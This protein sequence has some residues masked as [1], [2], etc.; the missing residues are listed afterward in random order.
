[1]PTRRSTARNSTPLAPCYRLAKRPWS[2]RAFSSPLKPRN[3]ACDSA[4]PGPHGP[5]VGAIPRKLDTGGLS[6]HSTP[7]L[8][9]KILRA[10]QRAPAR[11]GPGG[12]RPPKGVPGA[13]SR[14]ASGAAFPL[15]PSGQKLVLRRKRKKEKK[16]KKKSC[17]SKTSWRSIWPTAE[18]GVPSW[19]TKCNNQ[20]KRSWRWW[21]GS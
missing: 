1:M 21:S 8:K 19:F 6:L 20:E 12:A 14:S 5:A 9:I 4:C 17:L 16:K 11:F 3:C 13:M 18:G 2:S 15:P 7:F 10:V